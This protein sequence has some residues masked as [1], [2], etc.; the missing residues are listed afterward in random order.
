MILFGVWIAQP[1]NNEP[2][3]FA[4]WV[5][6]DSPCKKVVCVDKFQR[7]EFQLFSVCD[8]VC[9]DFDRRKVHI[10][11]EKMK[12]I[13]V[14]ED[15]GFQLEDRDLVQVE[16]HFDGYTWIHLD[17]DWTN[18]ES[19]SNFVLAALNDF[20]SIQLPFAFDQVIFPY[21]DMDQLSM[22]YDTRWI[23]R[24]LQL[25]VDVQ[26]V[27]SEH[28]S[29]GNAKF[30]DKSQVPIRNSTFNCF[31]RMILKDTRKESLRIPGNSL[32]SDFPSIY[33]SYLQSSIS[34][35]SRSLILFLKSTNWHTPDQLD[36]TQTLCISSTS[37]LSPDSSLS[38]LCADTLRPD[39][40][41]LI[42]RARI[43]LS[44]PSPLLSLS[45]SLLSSQQIIQ[46]SRTI[47]S[48]NITAFL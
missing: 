45:K 21:L 23:F 3:T 12:N 13:R 8:Q 28:S 43:I 22:H 20:T 36:H 15:F 35:N 46:L 14:F 9:L 18:S 24:F 48:I 31:S 7:V 11:L 5:E 1:Q 2:C 37:F 17:F 41:N 33:N 6:K 4:I 10:S 19:F 32:S 25:V 42:T 34:P 27:F 44:Y 30:L 39:I 38:I 29:P 16:R 26:R 40:F 47:S